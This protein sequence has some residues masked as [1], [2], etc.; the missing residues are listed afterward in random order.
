MTRRIVVA[1]G[2]ALLLGACAAV[3]PD[4]ERPAMSLPGAY[5]DA[6]VDLPAAA[7][8]P[9]EW[10]KLFGDQ[11]LDELVA[12]ALERNADMRIA[13]ARI[14]ETDANLREAGAAFLPEI[15]LAATPQ[16][17]RISGATATPVPSS[18]PLV[19]NDIRLALGTSYELDFWG[20]LRRALE[21]TRASAL[22]SRYAKEVVTLS[23]AGLTAQAYFALRSLD[24]G[25]HGW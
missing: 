25:S 20:K 24:A 7:A 19:R 14:E 16:R 21:A 11:R 12:S 9:A 23:L 13:V 22:G 2:A 4:Y 1:L 5:P 8:V 3:G 18:I 6:P 10:W 17:Q 15:D